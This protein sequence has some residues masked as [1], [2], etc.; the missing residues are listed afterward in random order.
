MNMVQ[1]SGFMMGLKEGVLFC[2]S[3]GGKVCGVSLKIEVK[4]KGKEVWFEC[5]QHE[6]DLGSSSST[7]V[8]GSVL[9]LAVADM[10]PR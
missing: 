2:I 5:T 4:M 7:L 8:E 3:K 9:Y 6:E 1:E 10:S